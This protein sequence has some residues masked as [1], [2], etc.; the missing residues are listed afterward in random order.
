MARAIGHGNFWTPADEERLRELYPAT[1]TSELA[2]IF[3]RSKKAIASRAKVLKVVKAVGH[4]GKVE[5]TPERIRQLKR[6]YPDMPTDVLAKRLGVSILAA[7]Q[8]A[9]KLG[10]HKS[11]AYLERKKAEEA[12]R[13]TA[14]GV[15]SRF[16][17]GQTPQNKG[18]HRPGYSI[19]RGRMQETQFKKGERSGIA[20]KN[21]RPIGTILPDHEGYLRIKV[22]EARPGEAYG[23]GNCKAWPLLNRHVWEQHHGPIPPSHS[24]I[25]KDGNRANCAIENLELISR[26]DLMRRNTVH[27]LPKPLVQVIQLAGALKRKIRTKEKKL[28]AE[29]HSAGPAGSP[30]RNAGIAV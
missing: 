13:L 1:S 20:N 9:Q 19:G 18:L 7:Y 27:N 2:I 29:E 8:R 14:S 5:W 17:K 3:G 23:F 10:I 22:R 28:N 16:V 12:K 21:W 6:F 30:V 15:R 24:V 26:Q 4:H 11:A 25:F